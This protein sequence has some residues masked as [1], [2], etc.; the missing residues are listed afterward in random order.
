MAVNTIE[1]DLVV[2]DDNAVA[3]GQAFALSSLA[4]NIIRAFRVEIRGKVQ[5]VGQDLTIIADQ[6]VFFSRKR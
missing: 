4:P 5:A 2:L 3:S 6:V 1:T